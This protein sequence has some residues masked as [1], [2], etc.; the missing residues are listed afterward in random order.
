MDN[1][2]KR[3]YEIQEAYPDFVDTE[4]LILKKQLDFQL[5]LIV[6]FVVL[7]ETNEKIGEITMVYDGEI[8]YEIDESFRNQGYVT[9]AVAKLIDV[10]QRKYFYLSIIHLNLASIKVARKLGFNLQNSDATTLL[11][12]KEK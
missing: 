11:F 2:L 12:V 8:W 4:R 10:S 6:F 7:K 1:S 3:L 9:E 5:T